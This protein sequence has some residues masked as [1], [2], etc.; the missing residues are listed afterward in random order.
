MGG[1]H[2][3]PPPSCLQEASW[4]RSVPQA[5]TLDSHHGLGEGQGS[6]TS[7]AAQG[8]SRK[9]GLAEG[10]KWGRGKDSSRPYI[11]LSSPHD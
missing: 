7:M 6:Y 4:A 1:S 2:L 3:S 9:A 10:A 11:S 5:L 8:S